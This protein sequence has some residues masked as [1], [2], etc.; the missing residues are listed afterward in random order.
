MP[1]AFIYALC[2]P[3]SC[4]KLQGRGSVKRAG[5][6]RG[7]GRGGVTGGSLGA[8][9]FPPSLH[10]C[11][12]SKWRAGW[13]VLAV[14]ILGCHPMDQLLAAPPLTA[15]SRSAGSATSPNLDST[16]TKNGSPEPPIT[17]EPPSS[18]PSPACPRDHRHDGG[19]AKGNISARWR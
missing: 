2:W 18:A 3:A 8:S 1:A 4:L 6:G 14:Y 13:L 5:G 16:W 15:A 9:S 11:V 19:P 17:S 7:R 12:V 10:R